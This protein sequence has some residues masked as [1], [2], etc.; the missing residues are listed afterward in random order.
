MTNISKLFELNSNCVQAAPEHFRHAL[1]LS[2]GDEAI[3]GWCSVCVIVDIAFEAVLNTVFTQHFYI[4]IYQMHN[5]VP[6][7]GSQ[8]KECVYVKCD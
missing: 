6:N 1:K 5:H 3:C 4:T 2:Y 8:L 7:A